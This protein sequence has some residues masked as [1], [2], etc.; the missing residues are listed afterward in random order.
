MSSTSNTTTATARTY[1]QFERIAAE[2]RERILQAALEEFA[3]N[4]YAQASTNA[5]VEG[6]GISKGLLFHYFG[7]KAGLYCYLLDY[8]TQRYTTEL[9]AHIDLQPTHPIDLF[10]TL[11]QTTEFKLY[12]TQKCLL[13]AR[14]F[15]RAVK[16]TLPPELKEKVDEQIGAAY[17]AYEAVIAALDENL[18][19]EGMDKRMVAKAIYWISE[20]ITNEVIATV[21]SHFE[22][23]EYERII[24]DASRYFDLMRAMFY[25]QE[26]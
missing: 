1:E 26:N 14:L 24:A 15:V 21:S 19:R 9:M 18:L 16:N 3:N 7:D 25:K 5:I 6:A 10:A 2:K 12:A 4:D 13:E 17:D 11:Q 22:M 8:V 20:G 23:D